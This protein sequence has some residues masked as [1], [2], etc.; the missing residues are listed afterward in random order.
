M[1]LLA[2]LV[3]KYQARKAES[4]LKQQRQ[5]LATPWMFTAICTVHCTQQEQ[6]V[7]SVVQL[8]TA[9]ADSQNRQA[10]KSATNGLGSTNA[11]LEVPIAGAPHVQLASGGCSGK[12]A[13]WGAVH[14]PL[15]WPRHRCR[16]LHEDSEPAGLCAL[17][18]GWEQ[19]AAAGA[20]VRG[21]MVPGEQLACGCQ[22]HCLRSTCV[23]PQLLVPESERSPCAQSVMCSSWKARRRKRTKG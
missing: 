20:R 1:S 11:Y 4:L 18:P 9:C 2:V 17:A 12:P 21:G 22:V 16:R 23:Q 19:P 10:A 3:T 8:V 5:S 7:C 6:R 14:R 13:V 15:L